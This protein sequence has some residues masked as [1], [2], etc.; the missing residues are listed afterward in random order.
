MLIGRNY[1]EEVNTPKYTKWNKK[2]RYADKPIK[3]PNI[4]KKGI[5][6]SVFL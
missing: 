4:I 3:Q 6:L 5:K 1:A 2:L